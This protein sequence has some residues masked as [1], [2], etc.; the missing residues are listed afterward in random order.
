MANVYE[1]TGL[2]LYFTPADRDSAGG[3]IHLV[4]LPCDHAINLEDDLRK[5][6]SMDRFATES[7][8]Y[9]ISP[10]SSLFQQQPQWAA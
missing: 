9:H 1:I 5:T 4:W 3:F 6:L 8:V 2:E 7:K 10:P